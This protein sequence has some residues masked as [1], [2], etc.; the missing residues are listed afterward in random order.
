MSSYSIVILNHETK[1]YVDI[2]AHR[3]CDELLFDI[4]TRDA[5]MFGKTEWN[6]EPEAVLKR[7]APHIE[8]ALYRVIH[9][10]VRAAKNLDKAGKIRDGE[11]EE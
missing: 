9:A 4:D 3:R 7:I 2:K 6:I 5:L 11:W 8:T 1:A 10:F